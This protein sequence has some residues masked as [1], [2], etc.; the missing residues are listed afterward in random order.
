MWESATGRAIAQLKVTGDLQTLAFSRDGR[1]LVGTGSDGA[2]LWELGRERALATIA[3][4]RAATFD[5]NGR[6]LVVREVNKATPWDLRA[7]RALTSVECTCQI[8]TVV[9][10]PDGNHFAVAGDDG[11]SNTPARRRGRLARPNPG[12]RECDYLQ[13]RRC[14]ARDQR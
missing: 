7:G 2:L 9:F 8:R 11:T 5:P 1:Y 12:Q 6:F 14:F 13:S 3:H 4:A 10:S